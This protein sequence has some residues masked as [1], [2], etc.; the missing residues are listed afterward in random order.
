MGQPN[1]LAGALLAFVLG[2]AMLGTTGCTGMRPPEHLRLRRV[3][4][5]RQSKGANPGGSTGFGSTGPRGC[6]RIWPSISC[7]PMP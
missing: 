1:R 7:W 5:R 2:L 3:S 4:P 6:R